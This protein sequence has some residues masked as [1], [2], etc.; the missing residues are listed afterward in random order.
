MQL[1][2]NIHPVTGSQRVNKTAELKVIIVFKGFAVSGKARDKKISGAMFSN[3]MYR[4]SI[5]VKPH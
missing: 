4:F 3:S 2:A 1:F 5:F